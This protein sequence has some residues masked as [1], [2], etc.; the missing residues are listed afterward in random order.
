MLKD[1]TR[2]HTHTRSQIPELEI[3]LRKVYSA[4]DSLYFHDSFVYSVLLTNLVHA[5]FC[6]YE[7]AFPVNSVPCESALDT[8]AG[9]DDLAAHLSRVYI[10]GQHL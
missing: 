7:G 8:S 5:D 1:P 9:A 10:F 2:K 6:G 3:F 4:R